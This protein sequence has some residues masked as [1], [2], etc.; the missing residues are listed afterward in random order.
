M[1]S[2]FDG[3]YTS[4]FACDKG[5]LALYVGG[6]CRECGGAL[7]ACVLV[8]RFVPKKDAGFLRRIF[9]PVDLVYEF[10]RWI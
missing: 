6:I 2:I 3:E 1:R 8:T 5:H 7:K 9:D 4:G 10:V